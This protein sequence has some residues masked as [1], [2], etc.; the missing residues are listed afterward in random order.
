MKRVSVLLLLVSATF[1]Q[2]RSR[3]AEYALVLE[4]P[5]VAQKAQSRVALQSAEAQAHLQKVRGAQR[6][7]LAELAARKV[8]V[9]ATSQILVNA[10]FVR[11]A[12]QDAAALKNIPGV[13]WMQYLPPLKPLLNAA[14]NLVGVPTAWSTVGGS[15]NAGAGVKIGI[16]DTGIDQNHPGFKDTGFTPP[17]GFPKGDTGYTNNKVIVARSYLSYM[18]SDPVYTTPEDLSPR[19]HQGHGTAIAMIAAGVQNAGPL[20]SITGVAPKAFLGNYKIFGSPGVYEYTSYSIW[21]YA[22]TDA[23]QDGMDIVTLSI[24][25]GDPAIFA[26]LDS[27]V[28]AEEVTSPDDMPETSY[29][30]RAKLTMQTPSDDAK[31]TQVNERVRVLKERNHLLVSNTGPKRD[32]YSYCVKCGRIE[33]SSDPTPLLSAPHRKPYPDEKE[34]TCGG[35]ATTRHIVLGTDFITDIALFS[36]D[37]AAPLQLKPGYYPTDVALRTVSDALAKAASQMLEIEPGELMA[38]YRPSL[39]P[40][41]REGL[42]AEIFLYD[43]LPGGAGFSSQLVESGTELFQRALQLVKTCPENC[44]ASCYRCL[45]S[46]K[47]KFEH[48]DR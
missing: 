5:P 38:E 24:G 2:A 14:V 7:V 18:D 48:R 23:V 36:M 34:P 32:G 8:R 40:A 22:L 15:A 30:T 20:G 28:A 47:N 16:I 44:D 31:W 10:I 25:E 41:G 43:T 3:L 13:K 4:D 26:P 12:P 42:K 35:A 1:A 39:T 6:L 46:F 17:S 21:Q 19:D 27:G 29:A 11:V 33:A 45:R 9:S 37:V